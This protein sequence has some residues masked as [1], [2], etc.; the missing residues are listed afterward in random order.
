MPAQSPYFNAKDKGNSR[1]KPASS[2]SSRASS[3]ARS[4]AAAKNTSIL[5][6]FKKT[7][8]PPGS[9]QARITQFISRHRQGNDSDSKQPEVVDTSGGLFF[10]DDISKERVKEED[11]DSLFEGS[12]PALSQ[13][14]YSQQGLQ[15][16]DRYHENGL[17]HKRRRLSAEERDSSE[18]VSKPANVTMA[19]VNRR[20]IGP[21]VD[22]SEDE[23]GEEACNVPTPGAAD[24][25]DGPFFEEP[26]LPIKDADNDENDGT[27]FESPLPVENEATCPICE[28]TLGGMTELEASSH[29]NHCLD[30]GVNP[31]LPEVGETSGAPSDSEA[32]LKADE[33]PVAA[34]PE[35]GRSKSGQQSPLA[36]EATT[37]S[38]SVFSH[39]M[40]E[41]SEATAWAAAAA[42]EVAARG[43]RAS[44]R[45]CPFYK[46][47]PNFSI[48]VDAFRYGAV[49][50]CEAYFLSHFHSDHYIGLHKNW[51]HG[52]IFCS[53]VTANLVVQQ[54]GVNRKWV[55]P[56]PFDE[57]VEVP[58]TGGAKV[59]MI[60]AN[61]CPGSSIFLFEKEVKG[62]TQRIL[63][64]G[65]FRAHPLHVLHPKLAPDIVDPATG[66]TKLQRIDAVYLD[67]TYLN[68]KYGFPNQEDVIEA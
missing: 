9:D 13:Q 25:K 50:G 11:N 46:I 53:K 32:S 58:H 42:K 40:S 8:R 55:K 68:P 61:H 29:V 54:L 5:S 66:K 12:Q 67:T 27:A 49:E 38:A 48:C 14:P 15:D 44:E 24:T 59:T 35:K 17:P 43:K 7:D 36:I 45:Q 20:R 64:C 57:T 2:R 41:N 1:N 16:E 4:A 56:L 19:E 65:D 47:L 26:V 23:D 31:A 34:A 18:G 10:D 3:N 33:S 51:C 37:K 62:R 22:E 52:P 60:T 6:F 28:V 39:M 30:A 63:H 21:F